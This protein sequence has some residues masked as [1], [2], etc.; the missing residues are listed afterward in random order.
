MR[1]I[2]ELLRL[3]KP[4]LLWSVAWLHRKHGYLGHL[5][6]RPSDH[7][8]RQELLSPM[9]QQRPGPAS[10]CQRWVARMCR[11]FFGCPTVGLET[12]SNLYVDKEEWLSLFPVV[13]QEHGIN[14]SDP[15]SVNRNTWLRWRDP[16]LA[17]TAW[18]R[19]VLFDRGIHDDAWCFRWLC[20][21]SGWIELSL[22]GTMREAFAGFIPLFLMLYDHLFLLQVLSS[23]SV[24]TE[25]GCA[26]QREVYYHNTLRMPLLTIEAIPDAWVCH[27]RSL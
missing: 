8:A 22:G 19:A 14:I 25:Y 11:Q 26:L 6:R 15:P 20:E 1:G 12:L 21:T 18:F 27:V 7:L 13:L 9:S 4:G 5:L 16:F 23:N 2:R 10:T 24:I 3:R 17:T